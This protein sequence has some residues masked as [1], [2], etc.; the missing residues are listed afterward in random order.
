[1]T[2]YHIGTLDEASLAALQAGEPEAADADAAPRE[3]F[4]QPKAWMKGIL[5]T[6]TAVSP[7]S[8]IFTF[9]LEHADQRVGLPVGQ[10]LMM[11]LRDPVT[12]EA[13]IR[14]Y[15]PISDAATARGRLDVL[16]KIYRGTG[17]KGQGGGKMTQA[18][19]A[20]P[21][22]HFVDF[23]GPVGKFEYLGRGLCALSSSTG[24]GRRRVR[25]FVMVCAGSGVTPIYQVLRA[26]M[27][28]AADL[29][30]CLVL[31]GSRA[32]PDILLRAELDALAAADPARCRLLH[33]LSRPS[34][35]WT[36]IRGRM[37]RALFESEVGP[38][39]SPPPRCDGDDD[40]VVGG[41]LVLVCGPEPL[42]KSVREVFT[43]MG[44]KEDDL[45]FF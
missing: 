7:D 3:T 31:D 8:K 32:E 18:L 16:I 30:H 36:G 23:R 37:D 25:R 22:G 39:P 44:W 9:D 35:S 38:P 4:L 21:L 20:I 6:K 40:D 28:D 13:I 2:E 11:R 12:R 19:D 10:H 5:R 26:V 24:G 45:V 27:S 34:D 15:T 1:M 41:D 43:D 33:A 29:T 17:P 14:A 42:E